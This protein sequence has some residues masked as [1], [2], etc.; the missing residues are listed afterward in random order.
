MEFS[1]IRQV[2]KTRIEILENWE[3][4]SLCDIALEEGSQEKV[5]EPYNGFCGDLGLHQTNASFKDKPRSNDIIKYE[6]AL[7]RLGDIATECKFATINIID[8]QTDTK[9]DSE[10]IVKNFYPKKGKDGRNLWLPRNDN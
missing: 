5:K 7:L 4:S 1:L 2:D 3:V 8:G 6:G 9:V 10:E